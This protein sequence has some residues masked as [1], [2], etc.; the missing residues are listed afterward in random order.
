MPELEPVEEQVVRR[1][2]EIGPLVERRRL[3][4]MEGMDPGF[5]SSLRE[6]LLQEHP[7]AERGSRLR[8][9]ALVLLPIAA[10]L[11]VGVFLRLPFHGLLP[12]AHKEAVPVATAMPGHGAVDSSDKAAM[13]AY[14]AEHPPLYS[15]AIPAAP[16]MRAVTGNGPLV[17]IR[18]HGVNLTLRIPRRAYPHN[19]LMR[20]TVRAANV[21][22]HTVIIG[23][24]PQYGD[25]PTL[26][27]VI[28][29]QSRDG[30][31]YFSPAIFGPSFH[32]CPFPTQT[33]PRLALKPGHAVT[34]TQYIVL[35]GPR[36]QATFT[37]VQ[38]NR[39]MGIATPPMVLYWTSAP[40]PRVRLRAGK[41]PYAVITPPAGV[42]GGMLAQMGWQ[43]RKPAAE[44]GSATRV[45]GSTPLAPAGSR[46]LAPTRSN[47][48]GTVLWWRAVAG[49][50]GYPVAEINYRRPGG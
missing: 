38:R 48:C 8:P 49:W 23:A 1:M 41:R 4:E 37:L 47:D 31:Q 7:R 3:A 50:E 15:E 33:G 9:L 32:S 34:F 29:M 21:S 22:R 39:P 30:R 45:S 14:G 20:V 28:R 46:R 24:T 26:H 11:A 35:R 42:H 16:A 36:L 27:P 10:V 13:K 19:A 43:C 40:S 2:T 18:K 25:C 12:T 5:A 6:R 17:S 44:S